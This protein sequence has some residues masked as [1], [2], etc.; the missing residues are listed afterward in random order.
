MRNTRNCWGYMIENL[1]SGERGTVIITP[2]LIPGVLHTGVITT[3]GIYTDTKDIDPSRGYKDSK[4]T[5]NYTP[6][7]REIPVKELKTDRILWK[8]EYTG[9]KLNSLWV[10]LCI[11]GTCILHW[12][13]W[14]GGDPPLSILKLVAIMTIHAINTGSK[15]KT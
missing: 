10:F 8:K 5:L 14:A 1:W 6:E 15:R 9:T 7:Y 12:K 4:N 2:S 3:H 11:A 13:K